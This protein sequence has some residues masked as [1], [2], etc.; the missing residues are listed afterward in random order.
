[1]IIDP[2]ITATE[3]ID[4]WT[5]GNITYVLDTLEHDHPGLTALVITQGATDG[6][7]SPSDC[8]SITNLLIE[9]RMERVDK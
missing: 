7:L 8:F 4:S 5:N 3:L 6:T 1:M 2:D 9:R